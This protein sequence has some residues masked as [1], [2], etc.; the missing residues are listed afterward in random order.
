MRFNFVRCSLFAVL[1]VAGG[2]AQA[3]LCMDDFEIFNKLGVSATRVDSSKLRVRVP[4]GQNTMTPPFVTGYKISP[5][6]MPVS[7]KIARLRVT[8][9]VGEEG[10]AHTAGT[11]KLEAGN[12]VFFPKF[13]TRT[14]AQVFVELEGQQDSVYGLV[15]PNKPECIESNR[16][17]FE[18]LLRAYQ[19]DWPVQLRL[20]KGS[21]TSVLVSITESEGQSFHE[22]RE[23]GGRLITSVAVQ[24]APFLINP[25][26]LPPKPIPGP[27]P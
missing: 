12:T 27:K 15:M 7:G 18:T 20:L 1:L 13:G 19:N 8:D 14:I 16:A 10:T 2:P 5:V 23:L 6:F 26:P 11:T 21:L 17:M 24:R 4:V 9:N 3:H 22:E 25:G